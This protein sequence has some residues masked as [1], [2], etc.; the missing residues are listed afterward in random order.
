MPRDELWRRVDEALEAVGLDLPRSHPTSRLSGGQKQR[1]AL[2]SI[3]AMRPGLVLLDEPTA[4]LDP[5]GVAE[6]RDAVDRLARLGSTL[7]V[8]EHRVAAWID[9]VTRVDRARAAG[10][11]ILADG[12]IAEVLERDGATA[13]GRRGSGCPDSRARA[14]R[15]SADASGRRC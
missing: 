7:V 11:S 2:A 12:P 1:L 8:V 3:I 9:V 15:D 4:N 13:R 10:G 14:G 5:D 6:V